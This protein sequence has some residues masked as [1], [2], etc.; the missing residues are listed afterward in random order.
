MPLCDYQEVSFPHE[1][2]RPAKL[3]HLLA[4]SAPGSSG[5]RS[6]PSL[7]KNCT[8]ARKKRVSVGVNMQHS[9][10]GGLGA[11]GSSLCSASTSLGENDPWKQESTLPIVFRGRRSSGGLTPPDFGALRRRPRGLLGALASAASS[12]AEPAA[13]EHTLRYAL[14]SPGRTRVGAAQP[15][16]G[17]ATPR[18]ADL[19]SWNGPRDR[20]STLG[21]LAARDLPMLSR[22]LLRLLPVASN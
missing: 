3:L 13:R 12:P 20:G 19:C 7:P 14:P 10:V 16:A 11:T 15:P 17:H 9:P 2:T 6:I 5:A 1:E 4:S 8:G 18:G 21:D 22:R